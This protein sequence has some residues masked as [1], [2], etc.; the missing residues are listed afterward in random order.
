LEKSIVKNPWEYTVG[1][2]N[3]ENMAGRVRRREPKQVYRD[4]NGLVEDTA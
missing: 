2:F 3:K 1:P 4:S